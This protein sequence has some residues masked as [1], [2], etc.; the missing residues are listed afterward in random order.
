MISSSMEAGRCVPHPCR[1]CCLLPN[2][3][4]RGNTCNVVAHAV[5]MLGLSMM[6][7][8][9]LVIVMETRSRW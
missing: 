6:S 2:E 5:T 7:A 3:L 1:G 9:V 4:K 8:T